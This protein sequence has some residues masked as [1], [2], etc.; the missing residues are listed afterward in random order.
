MSKKDKKITILEEVVTKLKDQNLQ[1]KSLY[2]KVQQKM[3]SQEEKM[4]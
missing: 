4:S 1:F 3:E 2:L